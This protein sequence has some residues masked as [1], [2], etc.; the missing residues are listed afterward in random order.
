[1]RKFLPLAAG[2]VLTSTALASTEG[3]SWL[4]LDADIAQLST[5][6]VE[7]DGAK[8]TGFLRAYFNSDSD[9]DLQG[10]AF[11]HIR[12][13][14]NAKVEGYKVR[15]STEMKSGTARLADAWAYWELT[16]GVMARAGNFKQPFLST[17]GFLR[18][19]HRLFHKVT[20][21]A[22]HGKREAGL[23]LNG[24]LMEKKL[25]WWVAAMNG[26]DGAS[27]DHSFY[28]RV[29]YDFGEK[30]AF[31]KFEG[32]IDAP[33]DG[34]NVS[35][36]LAYNDDQNDAAGGQRMAVE[37]VGEGSGLYVHAEMVEYDEDFVGADKLLGT[38]LMDTNPLAFTGAYMVG[39]D[40]ELALRYEDFDDAADSNRMT[41][42]FNYYQVLPHTVKW[43]LAY[44]DLSS[45][46]AALEAEVITV[47][48]TIG[49]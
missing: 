43:Q 28:G 4:E 25:G 11:E 3:S 42:G 38:A 45:D 32:A 14:A 10:W 34:F 33:E 36:S 13:E 24:K 19:S 1:M 40:M 20:N 30:S 23:A 27:E 37:V 44:T 15:L 46:T 8:V 26:V 21:S 17:F 22:D 12:I 5:T 18:G 9:A 47:G 7:A 35:A 48:L 2:L 31:S 16:D 6:A 49:F 41:L 39:D 29:A